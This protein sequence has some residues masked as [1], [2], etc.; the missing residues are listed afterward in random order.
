MGYE[1]FYQLLDRV[2]RIAHLWDREKNEIIVDLF[3]RELG[4][5]SP[6][7][8]HMAKFFAAVWFNN[9]ERYGFDLITAAASVDLH[10]LMVIQD[11]LKDPFWP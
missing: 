9:N 10:N 3:E 5:M 7:E 2:P 1:R 6:S 11:W 4:V 8:V